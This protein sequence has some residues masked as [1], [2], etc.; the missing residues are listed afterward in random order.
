[1]TAIT[2]Y[3][4]LKT[5]IAAK[6]NRTDL[7]ADMPGFVA[8]AEAALNNDVRPPRMEYLYLDWPITDELTSLPVDHLEMI[9]VQGEYAGSGYH[10]DFDGPVGALR[11]RGSLAGFPIKGFSIVGTQLR[12]SP[13]PSGSVNVNLHY[14][15]KLD[16]VTASDGT[17]NWLLTMAPDL[18]LWRSCMEAAIHMRDQDRLNEY[19]AAYQGA[20]ARVNKAGRRYGQAVGM[21]VRMG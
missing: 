14:Y 21:Q 4:T 18:Y 11:R 10:F 2:N 20:L 9:S 7:T 5:A 19:G 15:R 6:M 1:M 17:T 12:V 3:G 13:P 16:T 8:N